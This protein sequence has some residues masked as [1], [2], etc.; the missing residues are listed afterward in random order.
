M[1]RMAAANPMMQQQMRKQAPNNNQLQQIVYQN[2]VQNPQ[3]FNSVAWQSSV[4]T[5]DRLGRIMN[6]YVIQAA[7]LLGCNIGLEAGNP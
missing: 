6:L 2:L 7:L 1:Q 4:S 5:G 3:S